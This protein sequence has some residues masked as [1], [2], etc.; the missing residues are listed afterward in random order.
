MT[1]PRTTLTWTRTLLQPLANR[2]GVQRR[3]VIFRFH[4][5]LSDKK[6]A[7]FMDTFVAPK[8]MIKYRFAHVRDNLN[9]SSIKLNTI[10]SKHLRI[11]LKNGIPAFFP[12][13]SGYVKRSGHFCEI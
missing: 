10:G 9:C 5:S 3:G 11:G 13:I 2:G 8:F 4:I 6:S 1:R 12:L 7:T